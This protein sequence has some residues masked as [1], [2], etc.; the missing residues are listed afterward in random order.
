[1]YV[2]MYVCTGLTTVESQLWC[3]MRCTWRGSR[4]DHWTCW[5]RRTWGGRHS[6]G[7]SCG[8]SLLVRN[9]ASSLSCATSA[10]FQPVS[11]ENHSVT[12]CAQ[13]QI[14]SVL[15]THTRTHAHTHTHTHTR[16]RTHAHTHTLP[17]W[18]YV[19]CMVSKTDVG[20][21]T[22]SFVLRIWLIERLARLSCDS[23][24]ATRP[25]LVLS[26]DKEREGETGE[27]GVHRRALVYMHVCT[28]IQYIMRWLIS[29]FLFKQFALLCCSPCYGVICMH[30][31]MYKH[32]YIHTY[33]HTCTIDSVHKTW[34]YVCVLTCARMFAHPCVPSK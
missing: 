31:R 27:R 15:H 3:A 32:T 2:C 22:S 28:Y 6:S 14:C 10:F 25:R 29:V 34:I 24:S 17:L 13:C 20:S 26:C 18:C 1:M 5:H 19:H 30:V 12:K 7:G 4:L 23:K 9:A 21:L 33:V 8:H 11:E 16:A